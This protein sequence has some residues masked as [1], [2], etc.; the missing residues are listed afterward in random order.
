MPVVAFFPDLKKP[1]VPNPGTNRDVT[2][3]I[4]EA[5]VPTFPEQLPHGEIQEIFPDVF[6]VKGQSQFES[7]GKAVKCTRAMT[8]IRDSGRLTL[9]NSVRLSGDGLQALDRLGK[10]ENIV[11]IGAN[12]GRDDAFYS[13]HYNAPVW[14]L[15]G[16]QHD[17][18]VKAKATLIAGNEGPVKDA[19]VVVFETIPAPEAVLFLNRSGGILISCDS[20]Q[21]MI[22]P[23]EFFDTQSTG[24][25]KKA[26]FFRSGN[27]GP[28]WR[29][30]L[31]PNVSDF[32][33][34]LA[35]EFQHLLPSHGDPL[36]N[37][38]HSVVSQTVKDIY[39]T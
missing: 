2:S 37:D 25:M 7:Q 13:D 3:L 10:V 18:P 39:S 19:L 32:E 17:R 35:L 29:A 26:G 15:S 36:L 24:M 5:L 20:L 14:A 9:V 33:R 21:N 16:T 22:G 30:R 31:Q 6:F 12:H 11:R 1:G 38:A 34:I 23:D 28:A 27:I 8:I 4:L